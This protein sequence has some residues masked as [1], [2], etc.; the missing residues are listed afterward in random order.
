M[1]RHQH[2]QDTAALA[3]P[4]NGGIRCEPELPEHEEI[5]PA[6]SDYDPATQFTMLDEV[7]D[8]QNNRNSRQIKRDMR[9]LARQATLDPDDGSD[10]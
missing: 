2:P 4:A 6:K 7:D 1:P 10:L 8:E 5:M 3:D 9:G